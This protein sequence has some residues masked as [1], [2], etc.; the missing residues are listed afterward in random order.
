MSRALAAAALLLAL[1]AC[2]ADGPPRP[3]A[4]EPDERPGPGL[5]VTGSVGFGVTGGSTTLRR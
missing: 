5:T 1:A 2:G 4:S 3:P